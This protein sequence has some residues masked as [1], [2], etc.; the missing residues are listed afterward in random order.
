M[1]T[2]DQITVIGKFNKPHGT[3]GEVSA[4]IQ[5]PISVLEGCSCIICDIDGIYVPFFINN[6][7]N[8]SHETV[9]LTIDGIENENEAS[10][11]VNKAIYVLYNEYSNIVAEEDEL[12]VD[13]FIGFNVTINGTHKG[14]IS[15]I[16]DTTAN[17]LFVITMS[18]NSQ[19]L[20]PA[21]EEFITAIDIDNKHI[22]LE[23]P[24]ALLSL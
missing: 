24:D 20:V 23:V 19:K 13:F 3:N 12:P 1:I 4:T 22:E 5:V 11:I 7:R 8:K 17:V 10:M 2:S 6:I 9:L 16:D 15:D 14:V 21:V 18:D